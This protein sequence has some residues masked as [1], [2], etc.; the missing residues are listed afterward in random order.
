MALNSVGKIK[1][2]TVVTLYHPDPAQNLRNPDGSEMTV[3]LHGPYS[4]RYKAVLREQQQRRMSDLTRGGRRMN[5]SPEEVDAYAD[6]LLLRCVDGWTIWLS[7]DEELKFS[8]DAVAP[9]LKEH[10]WIRDQLNAALGSVADFLEPPK[11]H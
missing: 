3:T 4:D 1:Q 7:D 10:P 8:P 5:L 6:E 11:T 9:L 2:T